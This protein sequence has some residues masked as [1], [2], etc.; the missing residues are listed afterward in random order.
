MQRIYLNQVGVF[1]FANQQQLL[2]YVETHKGILIAVNAEKILH[3]TDQTRQAINNNIGYADGIGAVYALKRKG[4]K[5]V[6]KIPGCEFWLKIIERHHADRTFY[7]VGAKP[8]VI[9]AVVEH[10][11]NQYPDIQILNYR[12]GYINSDEERAALIQDVADKKPDVIFVA[13]GSPKQE[14]LMADMQK[15]HPNALYQ[16]LGG[17]FDI[18]SGNVKRAPQWWLD[19]NLEYAYRFL[20]QPKRMIHRAPPLF[21]FLWKVLRNDL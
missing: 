14:L 5:N 7:L 3:A 11:R 10:L 13:M 19:H 17:S 8:D 18:Y 12:D 4:C 1:P 9:Q 16:G 2:D 21:K 15:Q 20:S 6:V